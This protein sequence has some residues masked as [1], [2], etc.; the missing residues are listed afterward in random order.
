MKLNIFIIVLLLAILF[1]NNSEAKKFDRHKLVGQYELDAPG[2]FDGTLILARDHYTTKL[3]TD[4]NDRA[5]LGKWKFKRGKQSISIE[6]WS[7]ADFNG[8]IVETDEKDPQVVTGTYTQVK[9]P[10]QTGLATL[11]RIQVT[12]E[13]IHHIMIGKA[14]G[15]KVKGVD[16]FAYGAS[17][18]KVNK[19]LRK[20][21]KVVVYSRM[22]TN[23]E[24]IIEYREGQIKPLHKFGVYNR[25]LHKNEFVETY[26]IHKDFDAPATSATFPSLTIDGVNVFAYDWRE[27]GF[28]WRKKDH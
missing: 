19:S 5:V 24:A 7:E 22:A 21:Y 1:V 15:H 17:D 14:K 2:M 23:Q 11:T 26:I 18:N 3:S 6:W 8:A 13:I 28:K 20:E 10:F 12:N 16:F 25:R 4:L 27:R 9:S